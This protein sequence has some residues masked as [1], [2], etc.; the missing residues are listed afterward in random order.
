[1]A[2]RETDRAP[3]VSLGVPK[4]GKK[5]TW[6]KRLH[7]KYL[8]HPGATKWAINLA[9]SLA[10]VAVV[11]YPHEQLPEDEFVVGEVAVKTVKVPRD[12]DV[13]DTAASAKRREEAAAAV[14]SAYDLDTE[15]GAVAEDKLKK[16]FQGFRELNM[17]RPA[18]RGGGEEVIGV[19]S[20]FR[21]ERE[22]ELLKGL[23]VPL[24]QDLLKAL[25]HQNYSLE[26]ESAVQSL[27]RVAYGKPIV[28]SREL[29]LKDKDKGIVVRKL[30]Q[31]ERSALAD[32]SS[33]QD[34]AEAQAAVEAAAQNQFKDKSAS[35]RAAAGRLAA[36]LLAPTLTFNKDETEK[37]RSEAVAQ[38]KPVFYKLKR[39][40]IIVRRGD[41]ITEPQVKKIQALASIRVPWELPFIYAGLLFLGLISLATVVHFASRNIRKFTFQPRDLIFLSLVLVISLASLKLVDQLSGPVREAFTGLPEEVDFRYLIA[42]AGG[43]MLVRLVVNSEVA[44]VYSLFAGLFGGLVAGRS[45]TCAFYTLVGSVVAAAEVGQCRTRAAILRGGLVLGLAN[46]VLVLMVA[47]AENQFLEVQALLLNGFFAFAGGLFAAVIITGVVPFVESVFG[48]ATDIK[49][50]ELLNQDHP[51]LKEMTLR[52]PGTHQHSLAVANLAE[53]AAEA[54]HANPLL[55]RV[56][57]MYHDIGKM[58]KPHYFGENQWDGKNPHLKLRP[59]M[60][61]LILTNHVK[62]GVELAEKHRLPKEAIDCIA[63]HHGSSLIKFFYEKAKE[64]ENPEVDPV[65]ELDFR[66][67]GPK[68]QT[69]EAGIMMLADAVESAARTMREPSHARIQGMVQ[70]IISRIFTDGQLDECELTLKDLNAIAKSF[71]KVL[72][73]MYHS[74]P[75][76]PEPVEKGAVP[77]KKKSDADSDKRPDKKPKNGEG[78]DLEDSEEYLKR[79]GM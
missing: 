4:S 30:P 29:L 58:Q 12:L 55:A 10:V 22:Q 43:A 13:E 19:P 20:A 62:E 9:L 41:R 45:L 78:L 32:F 16:F 31:D 24:D 51:L 11:Y 44:L 53:G 40:E 48:Y 27:L 54:I 33:I 64:L 67:P 35:F 79:L 73:A 49:L 28:V 76:Y 65:D 70:K 37:V 8:A 18:D 46:V 17:T 75:D 63:Q 68:P 50:L 7:Q 36:K 61:A 1:M 34:L 47:L 72:G 52:A 74:R 59:T 6:D 60:S 14:Q 26:L 23:G 71:N 2:L 66:Y 38:V 77:L 39:G 3:K 21:E 56:L 25:A 69:R 42:L 57:A 5:L 15:A